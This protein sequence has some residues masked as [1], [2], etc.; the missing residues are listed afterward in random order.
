MATEQVGSLPVGDE[1]TAE[2]TAEAVPTTSATTADKP[3]SGAS[4]FEPLHDAKRS[5][6]AQSEGPA[7]MHPLTASLQSLY[8]TASPD[9]R[10]SREQYRQLISQIRHSVSQFV[11]SSPATRS[12]ASAASSNVAQ[13]PNDASIA[14]QLR[15]YISLLT[16]TSTHTAALTHS[17][18]PFRSA[19]RDSNGAF[20]Q[21]DASIL[22]P[23]QL[24]VGAMRVG[25]SEEPTHRWQ[26][27]VE[28]LEALCDRLEHIAKSLGLETF[29]EPS[30]EAT[31]APSDAHSSVLR[32][33]LTLGAKILVIDLEFLIVKADP[34]PSFRP[35]I[36]LK[37][38]YA[39]DSADSQQ[40][41]DPRLGAV[42][43]RDVQLIADKLFG[44]STS[45][46][47]QQDRALIAQALANWTTNLKD[48]L[49]LDDLE[50][51]ASQAAP[52]GSRTVNLFA[53]MQELCSA[54]VQ[55]ADEEASSSAPATL[56]DRGHGLHKL[57][58]TTPFLR[59]VIAHDPTSKQDYTLSLSVQALDLPAAESAVSDMA[60]PSFPLSPAA[61]HLLASAAA[62]DPAKSLGSVPSPT[63]KEKRVPL[64]FVV[65]LSPPVVVT[66]PTAAKLASICN[67]KHSTPHSNA[68][69][70]PGVVPKGA[71][72]FEDVLASSWSGRAQLAANDNAHKPAR[73]VFTLAQ[74][75][76]SVRSSESQGLVIDSLPL[77]AIPPASGDAM[78]ESDT[79]R[80]KTSTLARLF[81]AI[82][83]LRDEIKVTELMHSAIASSEQT[84]NSAAGQMGE[85]ELTLDDMLSTTS[86]NTMPKIPVTLAFRTPV[87]GA[88]DEAGEMLSLELAFRLP[89]VNGAE[90]GFD[91]SI[92]P[93]KSTSETGWSLS[94]NAKLVA[95]GESS[96][97]SARLDSTSAEARAIVANLSDLES[98]E[99]VVLGLLDWA[100]NQLGLRLEK[101]AASK[102]TFDPLSYEQ[103]NVHA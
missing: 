31:A 22:F 40:T 76:E 84:L 41:R 81:A 97:K 21:Q 14:N 19:D 42:L 88:A 56:L 82:E 92:T 26:D 74:T 50:A 17:I 93:S 78:D 5:L 89:A 12:Q 4:L 44:P 62:S 65:R 25:A 3:T 37:L 103:N 57:H 35:K 24:Q 29:S 87:Q 96:S 59:A 11:A 68:T 49:T 79:S 53:A 13:Q 46:A 71:V 1:N 38:S 28:T 23:P 72:W 83:V 8:S 48:L 80:M 47:L 51:Q 85:S 58:E 63:D 34:T 2:V 33:T 66:R 101:P 55:I 70:A 98:L 90:V 60:T 73:C 64:Q 54:A 7:Q 75:V 86:N 32:H 39:T 30:S 36:K 67:L 20:R 95:P 43:Q 61:L 6:M 100:E 91:A 16:E 99:D 9:G 18:D 27:A 15:R 52:A 94:A 102:A 10:L 45:S 69:I 77:L